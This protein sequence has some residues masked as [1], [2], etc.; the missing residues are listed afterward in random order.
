M[1]AKPSATVTFVS[2]K[3]RSKLIFVTG[4]VISGIGKGI[5]TASIARVLTDK[6][7][8]VT[9]MKADMY[10]NIDAGTMRPTVHGEVFVTGDGME[11][12][13]DLGHYERFL[14]APLSAVNYTTNGQIWQSVI[15]RERNLEFDGICVE[16]IPHVPLEFIRRVDRCAA[17]ANADICVVEIGGTVGE[18]QQGIFLEAI[19]ML[20]NERGPTNVI[21]VHV[22]YL[23]VRDLGATL[24][25]KLLL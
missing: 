19:R 18:Y 2:F 7:Y 13:E 25:I 5:T 3:K 17:D 8:K 6:G 23:P 21:N 24:L 20:V 4:G 12:D 1:R 9:C 16:V 11:T 10:V 14:D 22:A 15:E